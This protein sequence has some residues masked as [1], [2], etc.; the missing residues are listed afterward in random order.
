MKNAVSSFL[1]LHSSFKSV[2][3][4]FPVT[5][6]LRLYIAHALHLVFLV[7]GV[8]AFE[9][10]HLAVS[11][12]RQ[13]VGADTVEEPAVVAD[14]YG[15]SGKV[16]QTFFQR[17]QGVDVNVVGRLVQDK[18]VG[19]VVTNH[20]AAESES[21]FFASTELDARLIPAR[22]REEKSIQPDFYFVLRQGTY[23]E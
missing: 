19:R 8:R 9:E 21:R 13:D 12:K 7:F 4:Q 20:Q 18:E 6:A 17:T 2:F 14:Y 22:C 5:H 16:F 15:T 3:H 10:E 23:I 1:I 11:F